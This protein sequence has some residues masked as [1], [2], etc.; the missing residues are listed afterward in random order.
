MPAS[1]LPDLGGR[2]YSAVYQMKKVSSP[3]AGRKE[4]FGSFLKRVG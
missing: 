1:S 3:L 4:S 2:F